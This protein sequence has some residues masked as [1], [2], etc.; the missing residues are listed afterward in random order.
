[1]PYPT[2]WT[3]LKRVVAEYAK[4]PPHGQVGEHEVVVEPR[5][6]RHL[7]EVDDDQDMICVYQIKRPDQVKFFADRGVS[8]D[9]SKAFWFIECYEQ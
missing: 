4:E 2:W 3:M 5:E 7:F 6:M 1:M 8:I 9:T